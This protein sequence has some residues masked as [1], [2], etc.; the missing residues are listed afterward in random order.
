LNNGLNDS[1]VLFLGVGVFEDEECSVT[2]RDQE[3][4]LHGGKCI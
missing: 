3:L 4:N 2:H 1:L